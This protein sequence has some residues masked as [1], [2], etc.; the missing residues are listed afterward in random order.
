MKERKKEILV[1]CSKQATIISSKSIALKSTPIEKQKALQT[2][3][4]RREPLSCGIILTEH[5]SDCRD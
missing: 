5:G 3:F 4:L 2:F 1:S